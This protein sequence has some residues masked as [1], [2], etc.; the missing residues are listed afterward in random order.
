MIYI[1]IFSNDLTSLQGGQMVA[2]V[3]DL[4]QY[5]GNIFGVGQTS[6]FDY[7]VQPWTGMIQEG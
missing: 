7:L 5:T 6:S 4:G 2:V 1:I 3:D